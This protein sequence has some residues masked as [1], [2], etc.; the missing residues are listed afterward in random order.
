MTHPISSAFPASTYTR[1]QGRVKTPR[2]PPTPPSPIKL[3]RCRIHGP[4]QATVPTFFT[5]VRR[6]PVTSLLCGWPSPGPYTARTSSTDVLGCG[7]KTHI[8]H[9]HSQ[10]EGFKAA[11]PAL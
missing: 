9:A 11:A 7:N 8:Q 4:R 3:T 1:H 5:C 10:L 6:Y 2:L